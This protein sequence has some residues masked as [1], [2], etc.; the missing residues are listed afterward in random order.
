MFSFTIIIYFLVSRN[1][2]SLY[3][4]HLFVLSIIADSMT[5]TWSYGAK[6]TL[7]ALIICSLPFTSRLSSSS[8]CS[9]AS[10]SNSTS[11]C[12]LSICS[13]YCCS[14]LLHLAYLAWVAVRLFRADLRS[15]SMNW[16]RALLTSCRNSAI[17]GSSLPEID[18]PN[19]LNKVINP[20]PA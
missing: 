11:R 2:L 6:S 18:L 7:I 16:V 1:F 3:S 15:T 5:L 14:K 20:S 13:R 19:V 10:C 4:F 9:M 17:R 8:F 12:V